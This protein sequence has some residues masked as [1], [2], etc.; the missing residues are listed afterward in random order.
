MNM[1]ILS[2]ILYLIYIAIVFTLLLRVS[3]FIAAITLL[4]I[5]LFIILIV[6]ERS[7]SFLAYQHAVFGHGLIPIN[8]LHIM[9]FIWSSLLAIILYTEFIAWYLGRGGG[10]TSA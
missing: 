4:G 7:I 10:S 2:I 1:L 8:N 9:L 5:P 6:P 3:S